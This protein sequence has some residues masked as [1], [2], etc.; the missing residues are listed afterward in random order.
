MKIIKFICRWSWR[1]VLAA[2]LFFN[3]RLYTAS[4]LP[5]SNQAIAPELLNQLRANRSAI[6]NGA[7]ARMQQL[8]PEGAYF[9]YVLHGLTWVEAS[10]RDPALVPQ[11]IDEAKQ[12]LLHL[13]SA[14]C[15][16]SFPPE[17]PPDHGMF[18]S[19]WKV[20]LQAG[21]VLLQQG[22]VEENLDSLRTQCDAIEVSLS[23]AETPFLASYRGCVWPCDTIP[24]IHAMKIYDHVTKE[25]RYKDVISNW[26]DDVAKRLDPETG[27][28]PHTANVNDG[29]PLDGA[30]ATSQVI[31]LR[32]LSDV[33]P[34]FSAKQYEIFRNRYLNTLIGLPC[35]REYPTG[36]SGSGDVDSGPLIF[37]RCLSGTVFTIGLAQIYGDQEV[38]D[39]ISTTGEVVGLPWTSGNEKR[40]VGGVLPVG[41][42]MV[43]YSQNA[44]CWL[45][46]T[47]HQPASPRSV[48]QFWRWPVHFLSLLFLIPTIFGLLRN[49]FF[50]RASEDQ[51]A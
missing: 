28:I 26:L 51:V 32:L 14:E 22:Q 13:D 30:R 50:S 2:V 43:T 25:E 46:E 21:V 36:V 34:E 6:D 15:K 1:L 42:I 41:D 39:A 49:R 24:A 23:E 7:P 16:S 31:L 17:L 20:H 47:S 44:R 27:L 8:F 11:A 45:G 29:Q 48:S 33:D 35:V 5:S 4:P 10:L 19:A 12:A 40:Y 37:E 9:C 3:V 18:Y 38:A